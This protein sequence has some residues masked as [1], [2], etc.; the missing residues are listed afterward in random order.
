MSV[1]D[2]IAGSGG[3]T[4]SGAVGA[5]G[6]GAVVGRYSRRVHRLGEFHPDH[7]AAAAELDGQDIDDPLYGALRAA[8]GGA[9]EWVGGV[10]EEWMARSGVLRG[11]AHALCTWPIV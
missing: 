1:F 9:E 7:A 3:T 10:V 6:G 11:R 2:T 5:A 8:L 4:G